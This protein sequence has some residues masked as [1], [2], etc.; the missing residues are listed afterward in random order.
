MLLIL[1]SFTQ[2]TFLAIALVPSFS[3]AYSA[4]IAADV[5]FEP[6]SSVLHGEQ[7]DQLDRLNCRVGT[8]PIDVLV[9]VGHAS[10]RERN[11]Q[12]LSLAR[13]LA[14]KQWFVDNTEWGAARVHAEAKGARQPV[15]DNETDEGRAKNRRAEMEV[16]SSVRRD[17]SVRP[18]SSHCSVLRWEQ[19]FLALEGDFAMVVA[20]SLART[21]RVRVP[22]LYRIALERRRDDLFTRLPH[23]GIATTRLQ[24]IEI[25]KMALAFGKFDY[26]KNWLRG[27]GRSLE[28]A[29]RD[30]LLKGA[31][32]GEGDVLERAA[33][34]RMLHAAGAV[35]RTRQGLQCAVTHRNAAV[36][37][38]YLA[39]GA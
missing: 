32:K 1:R 2:A 3:W 16:V 35:S 12:P 22:S 31:C 23:A 13:A 29:Q 20:R 8:T 7:I 25:A 18:P 36:V 37:E 19:S 11:A 17:H 28:S 9:V 27:E 34:I 21:G 24:R 14:V 5:F 30:A 26:F 39:G 10:S 33:V 38:A 6:G 4:T 15:A